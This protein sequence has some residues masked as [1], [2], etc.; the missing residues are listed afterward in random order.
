MNK[1]FIVMKRE[2]MRPELQ[3]ILYQ[4]EYNDGEIEEKVCVEGHDVIKIFKAHLIR[5]V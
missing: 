5:H 2:N 4:A 1:V 3:A